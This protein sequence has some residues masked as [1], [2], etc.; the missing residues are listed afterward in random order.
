[1]KRSLLNASPVLVLLAALVLA[2]CGDVP[3]VSEYT[4][5][6]LAPTVTLTPDPVLEAATVRAAEL[7]AA[8][9]GLDIVVGPDGIPVELVDHCWRPDGSDAP[10]STSPER[11]HIR[12]NTRARG[13]QRERAVLHE[14]GHV[15]GA[16]DIEGQGVMGGG[17]AIDDAARAAV[18]AVQECAE[19][20]L[21]P[22]AFGK[23]RG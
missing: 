11:D 20:E 23:P 10:G 2:G 9:T 7:W 16:D 17:D 18:C 1:M 4:S 8:E 6:G 21:R 5:P 14:L 22:A 3:P 19:P 12:I 15:L 13:A